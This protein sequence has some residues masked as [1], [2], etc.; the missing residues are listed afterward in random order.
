[1]SLPHEGAL[2]LDGILAKIL[3]NVIDDQ[4]NQIC[5][6]HFFIKCITIVERYFLYT[7]RFAG[8]TRDFSPLCSLCTV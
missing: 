4:V 1:M 5:L 6:V 7:M 8:T 3:K 2:V